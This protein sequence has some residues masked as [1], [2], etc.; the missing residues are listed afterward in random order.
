MEHD[1]TGVRL[2]SGSDQHAAI[3][4]SIATSI[5]N[6]TT[7]SITLWSMFG[8]IGMETVKTPCF[9][10]LDVGQGG[11]GDQDAQGSQDGQGGQGGQNG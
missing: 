5:T 6:A 9:M 4:T 7:I 8:A 1:R 2:F 3:T 10:D 11:Q